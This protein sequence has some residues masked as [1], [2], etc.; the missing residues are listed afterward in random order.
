MDKDNNGV[1]SK[2]ELINGIF[3][4][5]FFISKVLVIYKSINMTP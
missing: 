3:D 2:E 5:M 1:L 4:S